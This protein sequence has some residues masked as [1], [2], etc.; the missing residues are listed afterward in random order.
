MKVDLVIECDSKEEWH[1]IF[2]K[3]K[4]KKLKI[5]SFWVDREKGAVEWPMGEKL[6]D[7]LDLP[8]RSNFIKYEELILRLKKGEIK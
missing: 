5:G 6:T 7:F 2:I 4:G 8:E 1:Y 3:R